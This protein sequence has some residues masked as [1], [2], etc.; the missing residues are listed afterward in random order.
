MAVV[1]I[2]CTT[3]GNRKEYI[4]VST[5]TKPITDLSG[6][7]IGAGSTFLETDSKNVYIFGGA[8]WSVL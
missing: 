6:K 2:G 4:G 7:T 3:A 5:D 1:Q 8:E